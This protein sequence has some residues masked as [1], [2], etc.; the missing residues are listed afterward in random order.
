MNLT[1]IGTFAFNYQGIQ[2]AI[3]VMISHALCSAGLFMCIGM[4]YIRYH[5]RSLPTLTGIAKVMPVFVFVFGVYSLANMALPGTFNFVGEIILLQGIF[6]N[7]PINALI[8]G[9]S[10]VFSAAYSLELFSRICFGTLTN[11]FS[12]FYDIDDKPYLPS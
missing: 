10:V 8:C 5:T 7:D 11:Y 1:V 4:L 6:L 2:G 9:Y 12:T 3:A